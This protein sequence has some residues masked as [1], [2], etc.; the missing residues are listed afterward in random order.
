MSSFINVL[1]IDLGGTSARSIDTTFD[2]VEGRFKDSKTKKRPTG[3]VKDF[4]EFLR[5]V[6]SDFGKTLSDFRAVAIAVAGPVGRGRVLKFANIPDLVIDREAIRQQFNDTPIGFVNDGAAQVYACTIPQPNWI[7]IQDGNPD[8]TGTR[9]LIG[10]GTGLM[11]TYVATTGSYGDNVTIRGAKQVVVLP[12][13]GGHVSFPAEDSFDFELL[14]QISQRFDLPSNR[15]IGLEK[16]VSG[17]GFKYLHELMN[18]HIPPMSIPDEITK[19]FAVANRNEEVEKTL[20]LVSKY[21]GRAVRN[22]ALCPTCRGGVYISGGP[23]IAY[24]D[25][26][27]HRAFEDEFHKA[28]KNP[29]DEVIPELLNE[30]PITLV[31]NEDIGLEGAAVY[32]LTLL[33]ED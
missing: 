3:G 4:L 20:A 29:Q 33:E 10:A 13:E 16:I 14:T 15:Y 32:A 27:K 22:F 7:S 11:T 31:S 19:A 17:P 2:P 28:P 6:A 25:L 9:G 26:I 21:Y 23:A 5:E 30:I 24:P 18:P 1:G 12:G 8:P